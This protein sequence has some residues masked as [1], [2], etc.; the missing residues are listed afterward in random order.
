MCGIVGYIGEKDATPILVE[1]LKKL[2]YRGYD[3]AGI[4]VLKDEEIKVVK[5]QGKIVNLE[6]KLANNKPLGFVGIGHT[7]WA[8]H[9]KPSDENSHPHTGCGN[10]FVVVHNGIIENYLELKEELE[11]AGHVFRSETDTEVLAHLIEHFY[12]GNLEK[13]VSKT[14]K[15]VIG[16]YAL[17]VITKYEPNVLVAARKD[18]PLVVGLGEKEN[19]IASD[20]PAIL[21]HTKDCYLMENDE[22]CILT[23][24]S[25][26][27]V[28]AEGLEIKKEVYHVQWD[29]EA[30]EK[31]GYEHFMIKEIHEQPAAFKRVLSGRINANQVAFQD[32]SFSKELVESWKKVYIIGCGT[33][34]H[35][36][37]IA[38]TWLEKLLKIPVEVEI[39]SEFRYREPLVDESN[40]VIAI[41]Q[42]GETADTLGAL[43]E[44]KS[45]G[46]KVL[47][48]TNVVGSTIARESDYVIYI[49]A[50]PEISVASTKAYTTMLIAEYLLVLY[51]GQIK[52]MISEK[53]ARE[54]IETLYLL[55]S[56]I[57]KILDEEKIYLEIAEQ[58]KD[59]QSVFFIGR[60]LD[61]ALALEGALKLKEVSYIHADAYPSGE[62]KHGTLAIVTEETPIIAL[63][64]QEKTYAKMLS[65]IKELK[66][67][68]A[69][70]IAITEEGD[71]ELRKYADQ[72]IYIPKINN[73]VSPV[74][75]VIP[76]QLIA[77]YVSK[78]RGCD[79]DQPR[80]LAKAVTVE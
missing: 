61:S 34:Y 15:K 63:C 7:R 74:L 38:K 4:A 11:K 28:T 80:N 14:L 69:E 59:R 42:S 47:S 76:L 29:P 1:G 19:F 40:L 43:R 2:E 22:I 44:A 18:S 62:L 10:D 58:L 26:R 33:A 41:S 30:A 75:S 55:P 31:G 50:G 16:S 24:D 25:V 13:A 5:A 37:L 78:A 52:G 23:P 20:M 9:G 51:L 73:L 39:A 56:A 54:I 45:K 17:G 27:I 35:A 65:N 60:G 36:G 12:A 32:F 66:A 49:W 72:V 64:V 6:K 46:A 77:Y 67:R 68:G 48:I 8:T 3:S 53:L 70:V 71:T 21:S 57:I 79:I